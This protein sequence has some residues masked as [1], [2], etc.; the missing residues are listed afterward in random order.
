ML[1]RQRQAAAGGQV[2]FGTFAMSFD[3]QR[4]Q[5]RAARRV[6]RASEQRLGIWGLPKH[7]RVRIAAQ[8]GQ[9]GAVEPAAV[10][11]RLVGAEP[12]E[13][14]LRADG[15]QRE[16]GGEP[17]R[18]ESV[19]RFGGEQ[20]MHPPARQA[21]ANALHNVHPPGTPESGRSYTPIPSTRSS[22]V[23]RVIR[24]RVG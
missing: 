11:L 9:A 22:T 23:L 18:A 21:A 1:D 7:Q 10:A 20:L 8:L 19:V 13:R 24:T 5:P 2:E 12:E 14:R 6:G 3:D 16:H 17:G 15:P 4:S